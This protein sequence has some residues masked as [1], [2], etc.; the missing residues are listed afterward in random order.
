MTE[1]V[2]SELEE[3]ESI[4]DQVSLRV[5]PGTRSRFATGWQ[6]PPNIERARAARV[7]K[8]VAVA[9]QPLPKRQSKP[10]YVAPIAKPSTEIEIKDYSDLVLVLRARTDELQISRETIDHLCGLPDRYA[11]KLLSLRHVRRIGLES[12]GPL[13]DVLG[14][15][16]IPVIDEAAMLRHESRRIPRDEAH[17]RSA[18]ARHSRNLD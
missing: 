13:L 5:N 18:T 16:L 7:C 17:W 14:I 3:L 1:G 2:A 15:K 10:A 8:P 11:T 4:A 9:Q 6:I 12:L